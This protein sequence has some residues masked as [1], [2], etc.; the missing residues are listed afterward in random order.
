MSKKEILPIVLTVFSVII[1][2]FIYQKA[3][4]PFV[5]LSFAEASAQILA[6]LTLRTFTL[7]I[8]N[9]K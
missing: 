1:F 2:V 8:N 4:S 3:L 9:R 6:I 5:K 7:F